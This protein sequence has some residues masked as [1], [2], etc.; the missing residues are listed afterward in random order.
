M[1][2]SPGLFLFSQALLEVFI[3]HI[4]SLSGFGLDPEQF[5]IQLSP[6]IAHIYVT[7]FRNLEYVVDTWIVFI[8][9]ST[10]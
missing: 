2:S 10:A 7:L 5:D 4:F 9:T 1:W 8:F 6:W 3:G